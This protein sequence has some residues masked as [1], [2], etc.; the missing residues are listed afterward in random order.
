VSTLYAQHD[1]CYFIII[2]PLQLLVKKLIIN[3]NIKKGDSPGSFEA[4]ILICGFQLLN[5]T[6]KTMYGHKAAIQISPGGAT[7]KCTFDYHE[8]RQ[9]RRSRNNFCKITASCGPDGQ[10]LQRGLGP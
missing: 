5:E 6:L 7:A 1:C 3:R 8:R 9:A 4:N 2:G 10:T